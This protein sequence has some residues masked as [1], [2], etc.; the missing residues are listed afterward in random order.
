MVRCPHQPLPKALDQN[1]L[2]AQTRRFTVRKK[3][4]IKTGTLLAG[5]IKVNAAA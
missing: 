1:R 2:A 4:Q 3:Q 5:R